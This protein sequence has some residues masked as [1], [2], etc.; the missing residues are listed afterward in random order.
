MTSCTTRSGS[1]SVLLTA[2]ARQEIN[3][4]REDR[5]HDVRL[6]RIVRKRRSISSLGD[7][8]RSKR[9]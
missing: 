4:Q 8:G 7:H 6:R 1:E 3:D 2:R 5:E 9:R